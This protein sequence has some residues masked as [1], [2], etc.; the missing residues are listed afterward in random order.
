MQNQEKDGV[1]IEMSPGWVSFIHKGESLEN[2]RIK[3]FF[4]FLPKTRGSLPEIGL[5]TG[6]VDQ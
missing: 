3:T 1:F 4:K 2:S 6:I 5:V